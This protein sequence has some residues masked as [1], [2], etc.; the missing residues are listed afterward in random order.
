MRAIF[1]AMLLIGCGGSDETTTDASI[2]DAGADTKTT[3]DAPTGNACLEA[4]GTCGCAGGCPMGS[5]HGTVAQD[6][7]CPQ[8]C[9]GCGACSQ[10][11]CLPAPTS[12][13]G[14]AGDAD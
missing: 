9:P 7:A 13:A 11:C 4:G 6:N 8:P 1:F 2:V 10:W 3:S 12:D 14:D 5:M